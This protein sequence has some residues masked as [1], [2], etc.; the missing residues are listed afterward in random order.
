MNTTRRTILAAM[1]A[2]TASPGIAGAK[3]EGNGKYVLPPLPYPADALEPHLSKEVITLHHDKHHAA[4]VDGLNK[5]LE[6][7]QAAE[8]LDPTAVQA[9]LRAVAFNGSG[10]VL[11]TL[12]FQ[13]LGKDGG[14][15]QGELRKE[16]DRSFGSLK[17]MIAQLKAAVSTAPGSGWGVLVWEPLGQ[18]LAVLQYAK[19]EDQILAGGIPLLALDAWE[20]AYYLQYQNRKPEYLEAVLKVIDWSEIGRRFEA[21]SDLAVVQK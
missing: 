18:R 6:K 13:G 11:H 5:A 2:M 14:E 15:P 4:Y 19:H 9:H 1:A 20:H 10:H 8:T 16:I 17:N 21:A 12:Y 7:L 3:G